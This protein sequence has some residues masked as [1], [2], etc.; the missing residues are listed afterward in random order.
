MYSVIVTNSTANFMTF[1]YMDKCLCPRQDGYLLLL[2][3]LVGLSNIGPQPPWEI[4]S[5]IQEE[6]TGMNHLFGC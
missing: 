4:I 2:Q 5:F 6:N 1:K 3:T